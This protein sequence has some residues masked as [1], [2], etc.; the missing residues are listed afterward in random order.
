[1]TSAS[2]LGMRPP[3][4]C[5][6]AAVTLFPAHREHADEIEIDW[7]QESDKKEMVTGELHGRY[8]SLYLR[9]CNGTTWKFLYRNAVR[10]SRIFPGF[11]ALSIKMCGT[12]RSYTECPALDTAWAC[13]SGDIPGSVNHGLTCSHHMQ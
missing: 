12:E 8:P 3:L 1:M 4:A 13:V 11:T 5:S 6:N 2:A 7:E 10:N 9:L